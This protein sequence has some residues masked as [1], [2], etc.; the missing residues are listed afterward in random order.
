MPLVTIRELSIRF[1][2]P[3]LLDGVSAQIERRERIGLLGRNGEGKT[4]LLRI[5]CGQVAPDDGEVV[6]APGA[7]ASLLPQEAPRDLRGPV[8]DIVTG[9]LILGDSET[10]SPWRGEQQVAHILA[11]ME[12]S[13]DA[14][15]E[16]ASSGT[17]RRVLLA[18]APWRRPICCCSTSQPTTSTSTPS[19]GWRSSGPL[20]RGL[21]LRDARPQLLAQAG[22]PHPGVGSGPVV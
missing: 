14:M 6:L 5:L 13:G 19:R 15:F 9:G 7:R 8:K 16:T 12:L 1:R 4:T 10:D 22:Q 20:G 17:Q 18:R 2:G 21:H 3:Q 11:R